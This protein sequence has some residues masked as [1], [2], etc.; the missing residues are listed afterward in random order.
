MQV[1]LH[2]LF[3]QHKL[4]VLA[5]IL[6]VLVCLQLLTNRNVVIEKTIN[7]GDQKGP[8]KD[9][10]EFGQITPSQPAP[11]D[12]VPG[13]IQEDIMK[14]VLESLRDFTLF[15]NG[16]EDYAIKSPSI[17]DK[18]KKERAREIFASN[19]D[20]L[21]SKEYLENVLDIPQSTFEEL[22]RS[23]TNYVEK[24]MNKL[25]YKYK[26]STFGNLLETDPEWNSYKDTKGYVLIGGGQY[27]W[28]SYLVIKQ[29]RAT[30]STL[31]IELFF[32]SREE[33]EKEFCEDLLPGY[34]VRCNVFAD[35]LST[36][37]KE[38]FDLGGYQY[39]MLAILSSQFENVI[40]LDSDNF[41]VRNPEGILESSLFKETGLILWP[42]AWARTT[43]PKFYDIAGVDVKEKKTTH[44]N[45]DKAHGEKPLG[46]CTF[47]DSWYH[48]FE[49]TLPDPTS[50][51]GMMMIN[52]TKQVRTLLLSLYYNLFG[53][54][55]Y[56]PLMTQGSA[57]EGDK[58]TFIAAAHVLGE[59]YFQ[60]AKPF[61]WVG[62]MREDAQKFASK[63]LGHYDPV[64]SQQDPD[65]DLDFMF[66]HLSYPKF[67]P[68]WLVD[69]HDLV[70]AESG[71]HIRMYSDIYSNAGYDFDLRVLQF[72]TQGLCEAYYDEKGVS[73]FGDNLK[74]NTEYMGNYL[75]YV[76]NDPEIEAKRCRE[77]FIPHLKWLKETTQFPHSVVQ[78]HGEW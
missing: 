52:K 26:L 56:Y 12:H 75:A 66:M 15:F 36:D 33:Y 46:E 62:Y 11:E 34:K 1:K 28:L 18:Y 70:Y 55:F 29:I 30:G 2:R 7:T 8:S 74:K 48:T 41:P 23:H 39:K 22:K 44:N 6:G 40:Y 78:P 77:V 59:P 42:D 21:F 14:K 13:G 49:G 68:N 50:E 38:R 31:P 27:S 71:K 47:A 67:Y 63:A 69:N 20:F 16:V 64:Q 10:L 35:E 43:N 9:P 3:V 73:V 54:H 25:L 45:Y 58:E 76:K 60:T 53:P 57:G 5:A 17:K 61:L 37:L 19:K 4:K 24:H 51:T 65:G 32:A 72:F